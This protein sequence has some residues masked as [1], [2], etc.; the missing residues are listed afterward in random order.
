MIIHFTVREGGRTRVVANIKARPDE[1]GGHETGPDAARAVRHEAQAVA[2]AEREHLLADFVAVAQLAAV[3]WLEDV[4]PVVVDR[5]R[6]AAAV[7]CRGGLPNMSGAG[8]VTL[9]GRCSGVV[10]HKRAVHKRV[11]ETQHLLI[12]Q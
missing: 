12:K 5:V 6:Y 9:S 2:E 11:T 1:H 7:R 4:A 3:V 10:C 8:V